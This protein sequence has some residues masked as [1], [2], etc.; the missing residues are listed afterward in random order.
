[1]RLHEFGRIAGQV[2]G[3]YLTTRESDDACLRAV[4]S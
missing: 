2:N 4:L 1:M 3:T